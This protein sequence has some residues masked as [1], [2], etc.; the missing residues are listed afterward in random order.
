MDIPGEVCFV[1][2]AVAILE[3][4]HFPQV[5]RCDS[6]TNDQQLFECPI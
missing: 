4:F 6:L 3:L 2:R 5:T 1:L